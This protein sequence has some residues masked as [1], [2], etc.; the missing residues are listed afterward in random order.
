VVEQESKALC[1]VWQA[2]GTL[3]H[4]LKNTSFVFS[5]IVQIKGLFL[6]VSLAKATDA[7]SVSAA[8]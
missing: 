3:V 2:T 8:T 5:P 4:L 1:N 6:L 7:E